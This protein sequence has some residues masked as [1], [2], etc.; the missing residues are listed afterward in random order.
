MNEQRR[1]LGELGV[2]R[3]YMKECLAAIVHTIVFHRKVDAVCRPHEVLIERLDVPY[4]CFH[5][6]KIRSYVDGE[7]NRFLDRLWSQPPTMASVRVRSCQLAVSM[8]ETITKKSLFGDTTEEVCYERWI[9]TVS[10]APDYPE[11]VRLDRERKLAAT[12]RDRLLGIVRL[13]DENRKVVPSFSL[14]SSKKTSS[15][16]LGFQ[17]LSADQRS[18]SDSAGWGWNIPFFK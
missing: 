6:E 8:T 14:D 5:D 17:I 16:P 18:R 3:R 1:D 2:P 12:L 7:L 13:C 11:P 15:E 4:V 9:L 10:E